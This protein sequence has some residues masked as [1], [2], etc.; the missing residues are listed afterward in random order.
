MTEDSEWIVV[1]DD[2]PVVMALAASF[3]ERAVGWTSTCVKGFQNPHEMLEFAR[4]SRVVGA[5]LDIDIGPVHGPDVAN[6]LLAI[7][8]DARIVFMTGGSTRP[9]GYPTISKPFK[10]EDFAEV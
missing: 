5:V 3:T 9:E 1:V 10:S 2:E 8:P 4:K 6:A 7:H